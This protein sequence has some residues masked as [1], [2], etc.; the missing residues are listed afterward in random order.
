MSKPLRPKKPDN[1]S[2]YF[3]TASKGLVVLLALPLFIIFVII[4]LPFWLLGKG[5]EILTERT[6]KQNG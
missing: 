5:I 4:A 6:E 3:D 1:V 2:R